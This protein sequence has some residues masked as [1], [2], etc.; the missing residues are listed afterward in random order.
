MSCSWSPSWHKSTKFV[1]S[2]SSD[3]SFEVVGSIGYVAAVTEN[4]E[5][6]PAWWGDVLVSLSEAAELLDEERSTLSSRRNLK[7]DNPR[8]PRF[9]EPVETSSRAVLFRL[10]DVVAY[11]RVIGKP[12]APPLSDHLSALARRF[13][14]GIDR[15][16][17]ALAVAERAGLASEVTQLPPRLGDLIDQ[18]V[19]QDGPGKVIERLLSDDDRTGNRSST[20]T[21]ADAVDLLAGV[22]SELMSEQTGWTVLDP[23]AG[24]GSLLTAIGALDA[25]S[26]AIGIEIDPPSAQLAQVR[27]RLAG[28]SGGVQVADALDLDFDERAE[29]VVADLPFD[30][31]S[32]TFAWINL[33]L[34]HLGGGGVGRDAGPGHRPC[35]QLDGPSHQGRRVRETPPRGTTSGR[36]PAVA[37][38]PHPDTRRPRT[39]PGQLHWDPGGRPEPDTARPG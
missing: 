13:D 17:V 3:E 1:K 35:Q 10:S 4:A 11:S 8:L 33:A 26:E 9:P 22:A 6:D 23:C 29:L 34:D 7:A 38:E 39:G 30:R 28:V 24:E 2:T 31:D 19:E 27:L 21:P 14:R 18:A 25:A 32:D 37:E 12:I 20:F 15:R 36:A 16:T 5:P